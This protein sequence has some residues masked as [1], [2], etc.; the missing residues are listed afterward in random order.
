MN[1]KRALTLNAVLIGTIGLVAAI[2]REH[3][4]KPAAVVM[5]LPHAPADFSSMSEVPS[6]EEVEWLAADTEFEKRRYWRGPEPAPGSIET[7][8]DIHV[9]IVLSG[10]DLNASIHRPER[11]MQAQG[12]LG[13][14][15]ETVVLDL[16]SGEELTVKR[17]R[18]HRVMGT[19][20]GENLTV[21]GFTYYW[22]VG[23]DSITEDHYAR[24]F[25]DMR[26]RLLGGYNQRWAYFAISSNVT[27]DLPDESPRDESA[28]IAEMET[29]IAEIYRSCVKRDRLQ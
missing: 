16:G 20:T 9:S 26:S 23:S 22:F 1:L 15:P 5:S 28:T 21:P 14:Q 25:A 2:P 29:L 10:Q 17:V 24:T 3:E 12:Y 6:K 18:S 19:S 27:A 7:L 8:R 11:C 4:L 13:L